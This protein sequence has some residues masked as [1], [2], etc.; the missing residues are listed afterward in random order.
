M[1]RHR[2]TDVPSNRMYQPNTIEM[3]SRMNYSRSARVRRTHTHTTDLPVYRSLQLAF[4]RLPRTFWEPSIKCQLHSINQIHNRRRIE[5]HQN[6]VARPLFQ[7]IFSLNIVVCR[8]GDSANFVSSH[9]QPSVKVSQLRPTFFNT[10]ATTTG[11][12]IHVPA[13]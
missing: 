12:W 7:F 9:L 1:V 8:F 10:L 3:S 2:R 5:R 11:S 4:V 6:N 13:D